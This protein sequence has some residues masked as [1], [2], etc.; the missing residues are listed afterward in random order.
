MGQKGTKRGQTKNARRKRNTSQGNQCIQ[1]ETKATHCAPLPPSQRVASGNID[2]MFSLYKRVFL[3]NAIESLLSSM[4]QFANPQTGT[5]RSSAKEG[6]GE[7]REGGREGRGEGREGGRGTFPSSPLMRPLSKKHSIKF[8][9]RFGSRNSGKCSVTRP[10][11]SARTQELDG[12][13]V[14]NR[15]ITGVQRLVFFQRT[16]LVHVGS[17][18]TNAEM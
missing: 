17:A 4:M 16:G 10:A 18:W 12:T 3:L 15:L 13:Q 14:Y 11:Q 5:R 8:H 1:R 7:G 6:R 2:A 9:F